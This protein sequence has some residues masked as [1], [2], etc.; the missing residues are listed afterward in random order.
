MCNKVRNISKTAAFVFEGIMY[1][2]RF[3]ALGQ[4]NGVYREGPLNRARKG[5]DE[6][7]ANCFWTVEL[8]LYL[9]LALNMY[10]LLPER[11][12]LNWKI[13]YRDKH[14]YKHCHCSLLFLRMSRLTCFC[15]CSY[16]C[17]W[18]FFFY[19]KGLSHCILSVSR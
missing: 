14:V 15:C 8:I 12:K 18:F 6:S 3:Q 11:C 10:I 1:T 19:N 7:I 16:F 2:H 4:Q 17:C 9:Y 13:L 5:M